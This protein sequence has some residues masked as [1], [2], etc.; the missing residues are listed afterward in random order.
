[1]GPLFPPRL[2][3]RFP[4]LWPFFPLLFFGVALD[5]T[6]FPVIEEDGGGGGF[7]P[8]PNYITEGSPDATQMTIGGFEGRSHIPGFSGPSQGSTIS[9]FGIIN[10]G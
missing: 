10:R 3:P 7:Y 4:F 1:M 8:V 6:G 5:C 2:C 9:H